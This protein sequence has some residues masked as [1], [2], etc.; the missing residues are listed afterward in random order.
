VVVSL[1]QQGEPKDVM[2]GW[3]HKCRDKY[4]EEYKNLVG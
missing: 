4:P 1:L 2:Y 3:C